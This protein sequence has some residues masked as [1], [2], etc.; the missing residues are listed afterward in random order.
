M[1]SIEA[2]ARNRKA[3]W[4]IAAIVYW[5]PLSQWKAARPR[6]T[7][8]TALPLPPRLKQPPHGKML[9]LTLT[10]RPSFMNR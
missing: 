5:I 2:P 6:V 1:K 8:M 3:I 10:N 9:K 7:M 4:N